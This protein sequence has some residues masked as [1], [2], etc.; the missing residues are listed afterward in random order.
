MEAINLLIDISSIISNIITNII[1]LGLGILSAFFIRYIR[2]VH[3]NKKLWD[4]SIPEKTII[5]IATIKTQTD[6]Y[7]R[8]ATG[9]GQLKALSYIIKSLNKAYKKFDLK[10]I[11]SSEE[12]LGQKIEDDIILLGGPKNNKITKLFFEKFDQTNALL[13]AD[14]GS[15]FWQKNNQ[16]YRGTVINDKVVS[17]YAIIIKTD[18]LFSTAHKTRLILLSGCHT[19]GTIAAA[20]FFCENVDKKIREKNFALLI[21]CN[22]IDGYPVQIRLVDEI[23][24]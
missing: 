2:V 10:N 19:Y 7:T 12:E 13:Q 11:L 24:L 9:V 16:I 23:Y 15:I 1:W 14:D 8:P 5:S 17:D 4:L 20:R 18:N 6:K 21:S 3:P 22:I